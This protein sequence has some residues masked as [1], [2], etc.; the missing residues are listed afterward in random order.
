MN[1]VR[2]S[3]CSTPS[4]GTTDDKSFWRLEC[5]TNWGL[6]FY[7]WA[8]LKPPRNVAGADRF[9]TTPRRT[10]WSRF[11]P[12][13]SNNLACKSAAPR[14]EVSSPAQHYSA[15]YE[16]QLWSPSSASVASCTFGSGRRSGEK[17]FENYF[18][19]C[20][21]DGKVRRYGHLVWKINK[22]KRT[23]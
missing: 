3:D 14:R 9:V 17:L 1:P 15:R 11:T 13:C 18:W 6:G 16:F 2:L 12:F 10:V 19:I 8:H 4:C 23:V 22:G 7:K 20:V 21:C 5:S